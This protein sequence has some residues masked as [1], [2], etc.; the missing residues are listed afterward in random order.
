MTQQTAKPAVRGGGR[1]L[2]SS[3]PGRN[4]LHPHFTPV[5]L[6]VQ[7]RGRLCVVAKLTYFIG[8]RE[9]ILAVA[10]RSQQGTKS[11]ISMPVAALTYSRRRGA[12]RFYL[13]DD[14]RMT[15]LTCDLATFER[16]Q[17]RP[18]GERYIPL[19]W[20]QPVPWRPWAYAD[21][22]VELAAPKPVAAQQLALFG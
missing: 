1:G 22:V 16:G 9:P 20:L 17:L 15:M 7:K 19:S 6:A 18:D 2:D 4:G 13:R 21:M 5:A 14:R 8:D 10:W 12:T 11:A 3:L